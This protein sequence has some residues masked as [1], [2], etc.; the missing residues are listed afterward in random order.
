MAVGVGVVDEVVHVAADDFVGGV[1]EHVGACAVD[2]DAAAAQVDAVDAFAGGFQQHFQLTA[3][4]G[5]VR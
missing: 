2:E 4:G 3:P 5:V 1:A